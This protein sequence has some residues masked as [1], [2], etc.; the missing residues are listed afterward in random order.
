MHA[1]FAAMKLRI[2]KGRIALAVVL[3]PVFYVL[4]LGLIDY[5]CCRLAIP[6]A[7]SDV[8]H[9]PAFQ[10][11]KSTPVLYSALARYCNWWLDLARAHNA[12]RNG[13]S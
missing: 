11:L 8:F 3:A 12:A 10:A 7:Y 13:E 4:N 6:V 1:T 2:P 9:E 5:F